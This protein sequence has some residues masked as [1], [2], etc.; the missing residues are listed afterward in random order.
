MKKEISIVRPESSFRFYV[1]GKSEML[2][3][4]K[5]FDLRKIHP[6]PGIVNCDSID[7]FRDVLRN[8]A[9]LQH[10]DQLRSV[11]LICDSDSHPEHR[12]RSM[13]GMLTEFFDTAAKC[14]EWV[15]SRRY[16]GLRV[17]FILLPDS[18]T[19]GALET[20]LL[21]AIPA[22]LNECI[23]NFV[24]CAKES[25]H[26]CKN[27]SKTKMGAYFSIVYPKEPASGPA[28]RKGILDE[29]LQH[30]ELNGLASFIRDGLTLPA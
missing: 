19:S 7:K 30:E 18:A 28:A 15:F 26:G 10:F 23:D 13:Q 2:V 3:L 16:A 27:L 4:E 1:E 6:L 20:L 5:L 17:A 8:H 29:A 14:G 21:R 9:M 12:I 25:G 24:R 22:S 11:G